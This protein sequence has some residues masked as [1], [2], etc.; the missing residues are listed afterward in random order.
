MSALAI[1]VFMRATPLLAVPLHIH[2]AASSEPRGM[3]YADDDDS[4]DGYV[5]QIGIITSQSESITGTW[6]I[7][8]TPYSVSMQTELDDDDGPL[9]IGT[10]VEVKAAQSAPSVA[11]EIDSKEAYKCSNGGNDDDDSDDTEDN[12][13]DST[14]TESHGILMSRPPGTE[15]VWVVS[16]TPFTA[17]QQTHLETDDGELVV[18]ASVEVEVH[19]SAPTVAVEIES[20][21]AND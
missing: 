13:D 3:L 11:L 20:E 17:T 1:G 12:D 6:Q 19:V 5:S 4:E 9:V 15:G 14:Q 21:D 2:V 16:G 8:N 18:G 7:G 10:C